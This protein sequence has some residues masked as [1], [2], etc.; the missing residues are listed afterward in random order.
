VVFN[1]QL[2]DG[3]GLAGGVQRIGLSAVA[4]RA[5]EVRTAVGLD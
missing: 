4:D 5:G 3:A 1:I 2:P